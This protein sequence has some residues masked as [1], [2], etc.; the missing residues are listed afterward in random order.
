MFKRD[1]MRYCQ[2]C[3]Q[4]KPKN[5]FYY[6][7]KNKEYLIHPCKK[8]YLKKQKNIDKRTKEKSDKKKAF[9]KNN[10]SKTKVC[11]NCYEE[12]DP[13]EFFWANKQKGYLRSK[14]KE[15]ELKERRSLKYY[16]KG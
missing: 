7:N 12:R 9:Y 15:C 2:E 14:C 10:K 3:K 13:S 1:N 16:K 5:K 8:C 6:Q 4:W 11:L